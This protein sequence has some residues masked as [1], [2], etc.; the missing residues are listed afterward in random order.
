MAEVVNP[1]DV[2]PPA[3]AA[4]DTYEDD[5]HELDGE[6]PPEV[7]SVTVKPAGVG[8]EGSRRT[9]LAL[10]S[11]DSPVAT[12]LLLLCNRTDHGVLRARNNPPP[13]H[14]NRT[15][16]RDEALSIPPPS[17]RH[18]ARVALLGSGGPYGDVA[19]GSGGRRGRPPAARATSR[20]SECQ[21]GTELSEMGR[22]PSPPAAHGVR[23]GERGLPFPRP[24]K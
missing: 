2:L 8:S 10:R 12:P 17:P 14:R 13:R 20:L 21:D 7:V 18:R 16:R 24:T 6:D 15:A 9:V 19:W 5:T 22:R 4:E 1:V 11:P 3:P 23:V